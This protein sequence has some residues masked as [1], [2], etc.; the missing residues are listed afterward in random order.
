MTFANNI[1]I[2][3]KIVELHEQMVNEWKAETTDPDFIT[4]CMFQSIPTIF[5]DHSQANG[6]NVLGLNQV[7]ENVVMLLFD[8][9][10]N[11]AGLEVKAREKLRTYGKQM[12]AFA[13]SVEGLVDWQYLNYADSYQDPLASYGAENVA[14]IRAVAAKYDPTGV[15]QTKSPT[16]FKI[17]RVGIPSENS[18]T[19]LF[20]GELDFEA[21]TS[22][23]RA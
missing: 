14:K 20:N 12:Q 22:K 15:F 11:G 3:E 17:S 2:Y 4:Q 9:A 21:N 7:N 1:R 19:T 8:I 16:G 13:S 5:T 6:G 18:T 23:A 10:V